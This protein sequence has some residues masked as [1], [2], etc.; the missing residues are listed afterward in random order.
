MV[1]SGLV[2][3]L[4]LPKETVEPVVGW[5]LDNTALTETDMSVDTDEA[6]PKHIGTYLELSRQVTQQSSPD[7]SRFVEERLAARIARGVDRAAL[8]GGTTAAEPRGLL[9]SGSGIT[10][11]PLGT[12]GAPPDW[13]RTIDLIASVDQSNA[14][15]GSLGFATN[16][17]AVAKMRKTLKTT[18]DTASS[19]LMETGTSL[20]GYPLVSTQLI[21]S[22]LTK[23]TGTGLSALIY[24]DW[25]QLALC[26]WS[27]LDILVSPYTSPAFERGGVMIRAM[28]TADVLILQPL[29]FAAVIDMVTT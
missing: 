23:G 6:T 17:K 27:E 29:A 12:D 28:A 19:F 2:G 24:G 11:V 21:P 14:L 13:N 10:I 25:S 22:D 7:V 3:N 9:A 1:L 20:A 8:V 15:A 5:V 4:A 26:F 18:T 16:A